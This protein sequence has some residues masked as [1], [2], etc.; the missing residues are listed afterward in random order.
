MSNLAVVENDVST[1]T[2]NMLM[3][4]QTMQSLY[5]F[6]EVMANGN[7]TVP[8]HFHKNTADCLAVAMQAA[9][10]GLNPFA[11][12]QKTHLVNG[13]LGYEAQLVNAVLQTSGSIT[14]RFHYEYEGDGPKLTCRVGAIPH[15]ENEVVWGQWLCVSDVTTKNSPL[16]KTNPKQQLGYLQVKNWGRSYAPGAILGVYT[17]DELQEIPERE[18]NPSPAT[19]SAPVKSSLKNRKAA[20]PEPVADVKAE[21]KPDPEQEDAP[22]FGDEP[23]QQFSSEVES[24]INSLV[25]CYEPEHFTEWEDAAAALKLAKN[26]PEYIAMVAAYTSRKRELKLTKEA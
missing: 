1:G 17:A 7:V 22:S 8:K 10:W 16:W 23:E 14:G 20:K 21:H 18:I 4:Q 19:A 24:M 2:A 25:D 6:A 5:K 3:N 9:Q 11:V 26:S 13:V 15:G 12:A